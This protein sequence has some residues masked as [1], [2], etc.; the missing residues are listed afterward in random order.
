MI[1]KVKNRSPRWVCDILKDE[2]YDEKVEA[3]KRQHGTLLLRGRHPNRKGIARKH[4]FKLN[5]CR[6]M[7]VRYAKVVAV[8]RR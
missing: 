5:F 8:Y 3:L 2:N 1:R 4:G 6:D 7:P